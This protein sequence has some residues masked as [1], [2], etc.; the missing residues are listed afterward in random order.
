MQDES[1]QDGRGNT[2]LEEAGRHG[3]QVH[4]ETGGRTFGG[5][6]YL[7]SL[8]VDIVMC[9]IGRYLRP[10]EYNLLS[11]TCRHLKREMRFEGGSND[12]ESLLLLNSNVNQVFFRQTGCLFFGTEEWLK[13][14]GIELDNVSLLNLE[15]YR[16]LHSPCPFR[17][18]GNKTVKETHALMYVPKTING[19]PVNMEVLSALCPKIVQDPDPEVWGGDL[20]DLLLEEDQPADAYHMPDDSPGVPWFSPFL[21]YKICGKAKDIAV[22]ESCWMLFYL[23]D[24]HGLIP[25]SRG[26]SFSQ[27]LDMLRK[28]N[29]Q[30]NSETKLSRNGELLRGDGYEVLSA[31]EVAI[32]ATLIYSKT[33]QRIIPADPDTFTLTKYYAVGYNRIIIGQNN[34]DTGLFGFYQVSGPNSCG[35]CAARK[36]R[37]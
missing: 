1:H 36:L 13:A 19:S 16:T 3:D 4:V 26:K 28:V 33:G 25:D 6:S 12:D 22:S 17:G 30:I 8:Q 37:C 15:T 31:L 11:L 21:N 9:S 5:H 27:H 10:R 18:D 23:G 7:L 35:I 29:E 2:A 14:F 24:D 34:D 32:A 20:I